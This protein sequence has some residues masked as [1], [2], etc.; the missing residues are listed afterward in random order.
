M[1]SR[2][3]VVEIELETAVPA[4]ELKKEFSEPFQAWNTME[5]IT[6]IQVTVN[7]IR[8]PEPKKMKRRG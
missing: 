7:V 1:K 2:R 8:D 6:P 4:K 3:V 5:W